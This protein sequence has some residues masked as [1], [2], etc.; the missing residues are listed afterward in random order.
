[1][2][3]SVICF[4]VYRRNNRFVTVGTSIACFLGNKSTMR[5][6]PC[7]D[8][9]GRMLTLILIINEQFNEVLNELKEFASTYKP[10][11]NSSV[12]RLFQI[13]G[14]LNKHLS[15]RKKRTFTHLLTS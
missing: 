9:L 6:N 12:M 11:L 13:E 1:L 2:M 10:E 4:E 7:Q 14:K 3:N 15:N 8:V 5:L